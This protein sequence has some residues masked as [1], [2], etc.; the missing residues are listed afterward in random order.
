MS[1][2]KI[3]TGLRLSE[4]IYDKARTLAKK[5]KRSLNNVLEYIV[6]KYILEYE[7]VNGSLTSSYDDG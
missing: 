2:N 1:T 5:E 6:Q 7:E 4:P 3:Q